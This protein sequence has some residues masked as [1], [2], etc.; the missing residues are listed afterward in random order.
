MS[1]TKQ[2]AL[3]GGDADKFVVAASRQATEAM[4]TLE[5]TAK[6]SQGSS[7]SWQTGLKG[8]K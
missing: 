5:A 2:K 6:R 3:F 8:F 4:N 7:F 1:K